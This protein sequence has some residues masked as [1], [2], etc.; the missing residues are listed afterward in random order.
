[1]V[2]FKNFGTGL[3]LRCFRPVAASQSFETTA[4]GNDNERHGRGLVPQTD[5][6]SDDE[7]DG[8]DWI[9]FCLD[10][11]TTIMDVCSRLC[12]THVTAQRP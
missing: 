1:M 10:A 12:E 2:K 11:P 6:Q 4:N 8:L 7:K 5:V 3:E 9:R